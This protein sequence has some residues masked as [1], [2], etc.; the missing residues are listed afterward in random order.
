L[1]LLIYA[2][3]LRKVKVGY[4]VVGTVLLCLLFIN[5]AVHFKVF[6]GAVAVKEKF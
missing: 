1:C 3:N 5:A 4:F 2:T 6:R